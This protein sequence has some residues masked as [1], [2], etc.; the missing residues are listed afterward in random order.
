[1]N[2]SV[3]WPEMSSTHFFGA[4]LRG[5]PRTP[6]GGE[7]LDKHGALSDGPS[8]ALSG[9]STGPL[10]STPATRCRGEVDKKVVPSRAT[11][12]APYPFH[13]DRFNFVLMSFAHSARRFENPYIPF[14]ETNYSARNCRT[15]TRDI[16]EQEAR[17]KI[18]ECYLYIL[19]TDII[20]KKTQH[21]FPNSTRRF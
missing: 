12:S 6:M 19:N 8:A 20:N 17:T 21:N 4:V 13:F 9:P 5:T 1:M 2:L 3:T 11:L 16:A 18:R 7:R 10:W 15:R 14:T